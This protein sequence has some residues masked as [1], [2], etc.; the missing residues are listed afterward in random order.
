MD[1]CACIGSI[2]ILIQSLVRSLKCR[3]CHNDKCFPLAWICLCNSQNAS[4]EVRGSSHL[5]NSLFGCLYFDAVNK[6]LSAVLFAS[7]SVPS[8]VRWLQ[9]LGGSWM[10]AASMPGAR[11]RSR[12]R[13]QCLQNM[14]GRT[15]SQSASKHRQNP[16]SAVAN[17][18]RQWLLMRRL[19]SKSVELE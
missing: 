1:A 16:A 11:R 19:H 17:G 10:L 6:V 7:I 15:S 18:S 9:L 2:H 8:R 3:D 12:S 14:L 13:T 4:A 5:S